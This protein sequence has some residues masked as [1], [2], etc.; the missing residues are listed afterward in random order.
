[1]GAVGNDHL[2]A[3]A[4]DRL[5]KL[6]AR[7]EIQDCVLRFCRGL[8]RIDRTLMESAFHPDATVKYGA[9]FTGPAQPFL[10][11]TIVNQAKQRETQHLVGNILIDLDGDTAS[12]ESYELA[13]HKSP[14]D[15]E[16]VDLILA[17]RT[18]DRFERRDGVWRIAHREKVM[19]WARIMTGT[20]GVFENS[21]LKKASRDG[22]DASYAALGWTVQNG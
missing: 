2:L 9:I 21:P 15:G 18:L 17:M 4:L 22:N 14:R 11:A 3:S 5:A 8:D 6:E 20:D 13:R 7:A 12:V 16:M 10:D 19:D 1:M